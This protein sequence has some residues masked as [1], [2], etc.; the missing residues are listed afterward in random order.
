MLQQ[1]VAK[2]FQDILKEYQKA[3]PS[4]FSRNKQRVGMGLNPGEVPQDEEQLD[5][6]D[7]GETEDRAAAGEDILDQPIFINL[8]KARAEQEGRDWRDVMMDVDNMLQDFLDQGNKEEDFLDYL[9]S[10]ALAQ[11]PG[12]GQ[13]APPHTNKPGETNNILASPGQEAMMNKRAMENHEPSH[14]IKTPTGKDVEGDEKQVLLDM[15]EEEGS[16]HDPREEAQQQLKQDAEYVAQ[17][18]GLDASEEILNQYVTSLADTSDEDLE[19]LINDPNLVVHHVLAFFDGYP[20]G[21]GP[22]VIGQSEMQENY[23][24]LF[25]A[26]M[27]EGWADLKKQA[28]K[29]DWDKVTKAKPSKDKDDDK[30]TWDPKAGKYVKRQPKKKEEY[31]ETERERSTGYRDI[32]R[33]EVGDEKITDDPKVSAASAQTYPSGSLERKRVTTLRKQISQKPKQHTI[34]AKAYWFNDGK[35]MDL[36]KGMHG[37]GDRKSKKKKASKKDQEGHNWG[38]YNAEQKAKRKAKKQ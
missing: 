26:M 36:P 17:Q 4:Y 6:N 8:A 35:E 22:M 24:D 10:G 31:P 33:S 21:E 13:T 20:E 18:F 2:N 11:D 25:L 29:V 34:D 5:Y 37:P 28:A 7:G 38:K 32:M 23:G 16:M 27:Q 3:G 14:K 15:G 1:L 9:Q 30:E 12:E 19:K